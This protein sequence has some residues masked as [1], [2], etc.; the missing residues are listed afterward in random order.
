MAAAAAGTTL[1]R[2]GGEEAVE[3]EGAV[4]TLGDEA[5]LREVCS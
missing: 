2:K 4:E 5:H 3:V 1:P